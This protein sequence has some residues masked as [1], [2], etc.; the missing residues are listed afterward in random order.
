[1][2]LMTLYEPI[3]LKNF[4]IIV[5]TKILMHDSP[6]RKSPSQIRIKKIIKSKK[7]KFS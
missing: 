5:K 6:N 3:Y 7:I 2:T 4:Q 1:M